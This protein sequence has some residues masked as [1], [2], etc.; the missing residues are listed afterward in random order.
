[1]NYPAGAASAIERR[2]RDDEA[3]EHWLSDRDYPRAREELAAQLANLVVEYLEKPLNGDPRIPHVAEVGLT[4][5][6]D[7]WL[8]AF[9][10]QNA[11]LAAHEVIPQVDAAQERQDAESANADRVLAERKDEPRE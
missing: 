4:G 11:M 8:D 6:I 3:Y 10:M 2:A 5:R 1:M 9:T 7:D